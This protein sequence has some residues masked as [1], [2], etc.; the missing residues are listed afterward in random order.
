MGGP[1]ADMMG[2]GG[3]MEQAGMMG[4]AVGAGARMYGAAASPRPGPNGLQRGGGGV[5]RSGSSSELDALGPGGG[6]GNWVQIMDP[7]GKVYLVN[8]SGQQQ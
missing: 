1:G 8:Q 2:Y 4:G 3:A 5:P 7:D 6:G